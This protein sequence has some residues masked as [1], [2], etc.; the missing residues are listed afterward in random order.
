MLENVNLTEMKF[1]MEEE[2]NQEDVKL[3]ESKSQRPEK[4]QSRWQSRKTW[5]SPSPKSTSKIHFCVEQSSLKTNCK[6]VEVLKYNQGCR[7]TTHR[8]GKEMKRSNQ[9]GVCAPERRLGGKRWYGWSFTLGN[10]QF[11]PLTMLPSSGA[12]HREDKPL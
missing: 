8:I 11:K 7:K 6:L 2:R 9:V 12:L 5:N 10:K 3:I 4:D 1:I